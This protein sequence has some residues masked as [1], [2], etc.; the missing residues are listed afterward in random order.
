LLGEAS[1]ATLGAARDLTDTAKRCPDDII[2]ESHADGEI[3][4]SLGWTIRTHLGQ[5]KTDL[6][7][8]GAASLL[9]PGPSFGDF[10]QALLQTADDLVQSGDLTQ[11]D[12]DQVAADVAARGLDDC[13]E[14]L[15]LADG[16]ERSV[17]ILGL[18]LLGQLFGASC[19]QLQAGGF[20]MQSLF[21]FARETKA[22]DE[23]VRFRLEMEPD[24][25]GPVSFSVF[26]RKEFHVTFTSSGGFSLPEPTVFDAQF[27]FDTPTGDVV[28]NAESM[29]E[30][31]PGATYFIAVTHASCPSLKMTVSADD[32]NSSMTTSS[33]SSSSSS[34]GVGGAGGDGGGAN[35]GGGAGGDGEVTGGGCDCSV[36]DDSTSGAAGFA[37]AALALAVAGRRRA[38]SRRVG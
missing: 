29:P 34:S 7:V 9:T 24:S 28:L 20:R 19:S 14:E 22:T 23:A 37:L 10:G 27:D 17:Q 30:F 11:E 35:G 32:V 2:G 12:A 38:R 15:P 16:Q 5:H 13:D 21:H 31:E 18:S 25:S 36:S 33:S 6:L 8:W 4:G 26:V 1:L 3:I